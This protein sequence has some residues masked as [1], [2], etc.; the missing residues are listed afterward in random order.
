MNTMQKMSSWP[1]L[2]SSIQNTLITGLPLSTFSL[3]IHLA[4]KSRSLVIG[5]PSGSERSVS[6]LIKA[7]AAQT[8]NPRRPAKGNAS[9]RT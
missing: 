7:A 8:G 3:F 6:A 2:Y 9:V 4:V 1:Y 5:I